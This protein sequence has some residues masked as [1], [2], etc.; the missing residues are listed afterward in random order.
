MNNKLITVL[1]LIV[2]LLLALTLIL[3]LTQ[4]VFPP[5]P[6]PEPEPEPTETPEPEPE[7]YNA[8][9]VFRAQNADKNVV[10]A[11]LVGAECFDYTDNLSLG[12]L[13]KIEYSENED[14][15]LD[16][17]IYI[18]GGAFEISPYGLVSPKGYVAVGHTAVIYVG[19]AKY[20]CPVYS[21]EIGEQVIEK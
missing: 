7:L 14:G 18:D 20:Y 11:S 16:A 9:I 21:I 3:F 2:I 13:Q 15:T 4:Y 5:E 8:S 12:T 6:E 1:S 10:E 17:L 19:M